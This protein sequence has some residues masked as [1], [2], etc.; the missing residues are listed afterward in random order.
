MNT[1]Y[2]TI[3]YEGDGNVRLPS[4]ARIL[5][6][7]TADDLITSLAVNCTFA[8]ESETQSNLN[9][10]QFVDIFEDMI[11]YFEKIRWKIKLSKYEGTGIVFKIDGDE[12][13]PINEKEGKK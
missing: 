3:I 11:N 12:I 2:T 1:G 13:I 9:N 10:D 7:N 4:K 5:S 6:S 8:L